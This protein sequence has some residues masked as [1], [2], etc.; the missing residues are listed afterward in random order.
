MHKSVLSMF[1]ERSQSNTSRNKDSP[2]LSPP[3]RGAIFSLSEGL[4]GRP[5]SPGSANQRAGFD[6]SNRARDYVGGA[7][8]Q[9]T[10]AR[11]VPSSEERGEG[12][13]SL[14]RGEGECEEVR[15]H[16]E[17]DIASWNVLLYSGCSFCDFL[18]F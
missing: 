11:P 5:F 15:Q 6:R 3:T 8:P 16:G 2:T 17:W 1:S 9:L 12:G 7:R 14:G 4:F 18:L 10:A 13:D